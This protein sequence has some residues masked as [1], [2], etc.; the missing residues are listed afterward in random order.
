[1][2]QS[3]QSTAHLD[4]PRRGRRGLQPPRLPSGRSAAT[5]PKRPVPTR[6]PGHSY[7]GNGERLL[8]V[9]AAYEAETPGSRALKDNLLGGH[10]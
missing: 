8:E 1:M 3:A 4:V 7:P 9:L 10:R 2:A 6:V 5:L